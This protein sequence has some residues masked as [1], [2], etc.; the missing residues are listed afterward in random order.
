MVNMKILLFGANGQLGYELE[1][2]LCVIGDVTTC[3][4]HNAHETIDIVDTERVSALINAHRPH[5]VVNA[6]AYTAVDKAE[7]EQ[8]LAMRVNA[9][10]VRAMAQASRDV[11]ALLVHFSTDYVFSGDGATPWTERDPTQALSAYGRSKL[12]GEK[13]V[14]SSQCAH[15]IIRLQSVYS[16]RGNNFVRTMLNLARS[17]RH[18][19]VVNDQWMTPTPARWIAAAVG[20]MLSRW[21]HSSS[22]GKLTGVYHMSARGRCSW[23]EFAEAIFQRALS[24]GLLVDSPQLA[25]VSAETYGAQARRP[26]FSVFNCDRLLRDFDLQ[27]GDW[28]SGLGQVLEELERRSHN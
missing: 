9:D 10:A 5:V 23:Y 11:G 21:L 2:A 18:L 1:R 12:E 17:G 3:A 13:A 25:G 28:E 19:R 15:W 20:M 16:A 26:A 4:R 14:Q 8:E 7:Q 27:L 24:R 22:R 6:A